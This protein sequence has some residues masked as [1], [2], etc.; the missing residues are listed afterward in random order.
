M[1]QNRGE[2]MIHL[3]WQ[4]AS[5]DLKF[6]SHYETVALECGQLNSPDHSFETSLN[7]ES[8]NRPGKHMY[9][10]IVVHAW[11]WIDFISLTK[12]LH[13][14]INVGMWVI[15]HDVRI[16]YI[17]ER[18]FG[19]INVTVLSMGRIQ[20]LSECIIAPVFKVQLK[21]VWFNSI[22]MY[23][24]T[25]C[26][27]VDMKFVHGNIRIHS[28]AKYHHVM[29]SVIWSLMHS[30]GMSPVSPMHRPHPS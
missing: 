12:I 22:E 13:F 3:H 25:G 23:V 17:N 14:L 6:N 21:Y 19:Y 15:L 30:D 24:P 11:N 18:T 4:Q 10:C 26:G 1:F 5:H 9:I 2:H 7:G 29:T 28:S 16:L 27:N 8:I 20:D